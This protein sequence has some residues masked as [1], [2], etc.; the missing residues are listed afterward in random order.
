MCEKGKNSLFTLKVPRLIEQSR[1]SKLNPD[2]INL[3]WSMKVYKMMVWA[4]MQVVVTP[5][6]FSYGVYFKYMENNLGGI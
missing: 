2:E 3:E 4:I 1:P 6:L 5:L